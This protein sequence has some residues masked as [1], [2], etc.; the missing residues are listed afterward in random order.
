[1]FSS[2]STEFVSP[3]IFKHYLFQEKNCQCRCLPNLYSQLCTTRVK[4]TLVIQ[5]YS[6]GC[7]CCFVLRVSRVNSFLY[8]NIKYMLLDEIL[9]G[10]KD[11]HLDISLCLAR[12]AHNF[13]TSYVPQINFIVNKLAMFTDPSV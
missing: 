1:M 12:S 7:F 6:K 13:Q 10:K 9:L 5:Q 3:L 11:N 8:L 2:Q 4:L